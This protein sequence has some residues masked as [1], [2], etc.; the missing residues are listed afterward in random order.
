MRAVRLSIAAGLLPVLFSV[1]GAAQTLLE[2]IPATLILNNAE[3]R[4]IKVTWPGGSSRPYTV[5]DKPSWLSVTS[6]NNYSAPDTLYFQLANTICGTCVA[7]VRLVPAGNGAATTLSVRFAPEGT[8]DLM[9]LATS[10]PAINLNSTQARGIVVSA[11]KGASAKYTVRN[12]PSWV[13]ATSTNNFTTPD[14]LY[15]Q[16]SNSNC[17]ACSGTVELLAEGSTT[18]TTVPVQYGISAGASLHA[19]PT[20][21]TL[22]YPA[23]FGTMCGSGSMS[24]C[25]VGMN[26][27][28]AS[29]KNYSAKTNPG[30]GDS[31][32][33]LNDKPGV[34]SSV[35][36]ANGLTFSLNQ[37]ALPSMATGAYSG[38]VVVF[39]PA[40]QSDLILID[41]SLLINPGKITV[42]PDT[43]TGNSQTFTMQFPHPGGW[44]KL[45][46]LN[47]LINNGLELAKG[48]YLA[49]EVPIS[50][51]HLTDDQGNV[52]GPAG[53]I[54]EGKSGKN[55]QCGVRFVSAKGDDKLLTLTL[56][57]TFTPGTF[58]GK[59]NIY[60]AARDKEQNNSG[61]ITAGSWEI[62]P[63]APPRKKK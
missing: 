27:S 18:P 33:L 34:V 48:C 29:V 15:F 41:V 54:K 58:A 4:T 63:P 23:P 3:A 52:Q 55:G 35:P 59:K 62:R 45:A 2:A 36:L 31:W 14:T 49:Y 16:V 13:T 56:D 32:L 28:V 9:R 10:P 50:T 7:N 57:M 30:A 8:A 38:Q 6:A 61:W 12:A 44:E 22:T 43:G 19:N 11:P 39:N 42:A 1:S 53:E 20:R 5:E 24:R 21:V 51:L 47:V 25:T 17:G 40:N 37:N 26:S 46:V 60:L